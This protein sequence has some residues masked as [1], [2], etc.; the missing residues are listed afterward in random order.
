[1]QITFRMLS[2][3]KILLIVVIVFCATNFFAQKL[4]LSDKIEINFRNDDFAAIGK[5]KNLYAVYINSSSKAE[6][7]FFNAQFEF[8]KRI[9]IPFLNKGM[10]NP[11]FVSTA[12]DLVLFYEER[13]NK[14]STLYASK[15]IDDF[16]FIN[17]IEISSSKE[18]TDFKFCSSENN[19]KH[20]FYNYVEV[21]DKWQLK[22]FVINNNLK[23]ENTISQTISTDDFYFL[24]EQAVSNEGTAYFL[25]SN[26][27]VNKSAIDE[28]KMASCTSS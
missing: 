17:P 24:N 16:S 8:E 19:Q 10:S 20:F 27:I 18:R 2:M 25:A 12:T 21:A 22:A 23:I 11:H 15:M 4:L 6:V 14:Q 1:M 28:L 5:Y 3:K 13:Q 26:R 7:V 9:D